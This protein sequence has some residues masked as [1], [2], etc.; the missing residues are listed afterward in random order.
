MAD[1]A[2]IDEHVDAGPS[3]LAVQNLGGSGSYTLSADLTPAVP[4]FQLVP[5][6]NE[7]DPIAVGDFVGAGDVDLFAPDGV[8]P[9]LGDGTFGPAIPGSA[10]PDLSTDILSTIVAGKFTG[11]GRL[12]AAVTVTHSDGSGEILVLRNTGGGLFQIDQAIPFDDSDSIGP[13]V[14]GDF[15]NGQA[16]LAVAFGEQ[17]PGIEVFLNDGSGMFTPSTSIPLGSD[18]VA[19]VAGDFDGDGRTG[20]AAVVVGDPTTGQVPGVEMFSSD[21]RGGFAL[22]ATVPVGSEPVAMVAGDFNGD[23]REDLAVADFG[24]NEV[25]VLMSQGQGR[26]APPVPYSVGQNPAALATG[27]FNGDGR[28]DLAV[29]NGTSGDVTVLLGHGDGTFQGGIVSRTGVYA[30]GRG[31]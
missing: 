7:F 30:Q 5:T 11:S 20:L 26:L 24:S 10:V 4:P 19:M 27:D 22:S 29:A 18:P 14:A 12:D 28:T 2:Q 17:A 16:D 31:R 3:V 9:G 8:H 23:G 6:S 1:V 13:L 15:G 21:G 25:D